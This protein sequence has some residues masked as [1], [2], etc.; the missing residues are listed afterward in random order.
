MGIHVDLQGTHEIVVIQ[1]L[2]DCIAGG[3]PIG[4]VQLPE[5]GVDLVW[6]D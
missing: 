4:K 1:D 3:R 2:F 5:P 6:R